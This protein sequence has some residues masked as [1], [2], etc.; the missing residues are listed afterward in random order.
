MSV[1]PMFP[2]GTDHFIKAV[3]FLWIIVPLITVLGWL[4]DYATF[5]Y[6]VIILLVWTY[7]E[8]TVVIESS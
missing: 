8:D 6:T 7:S 3:K 2:D 4:G 5:E 1:K